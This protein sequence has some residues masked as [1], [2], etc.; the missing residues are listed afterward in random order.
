M[1][2]LIN[3]ID[4][5][6]QSPSDTRLGIILQSAKLKNTKA[7]I[8]SLKML[9]ED[10]IEDKEIKPISLFLGAAI[11]LAPISL[12]GPMN[13]DDFII[14]VKR[15]LG[16]PKDENSFGNR[17]LSGKVTRFALNSWYNP[18]VVFKKFAALAG[19]EYVGIDFYPK[20]I[21]N[22][23]GQTPI[24]DCCIAGTGIIARETLVLNNIGGR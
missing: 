9:I 3:Q 1:S 5:Y 7:N 12:T 4:K 19:K 23:G 2:E 11:E 24:W 17:I 8:A 18:E 13:Q 16:D 15:S 20:N 22:S 6:I 10:Y 21:T 14:H